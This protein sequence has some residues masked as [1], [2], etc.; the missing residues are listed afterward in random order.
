MCSF[1]R[2]TNEKLKDCGKCF[3][4][5]SGNSGNHKAGKPEFLDTK[6]G[7][8]IVVRCKDCGTYL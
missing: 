3:C 2:K 8:L 4:G 1:D 6:A 5:Q 7:R